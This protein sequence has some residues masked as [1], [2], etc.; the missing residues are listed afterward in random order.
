METDDFW[1]DQVGFSDAIGFTNASL[2][3]STCAKDG[4]ILKPS[5]PLAAI[6]RSFSIGGNAS[7]VAPPVPSGGHVW[8]THTT[9]AAMTWW[10][11]LAITVNEPWELLRTDLYPALPLSAELVV[12]D[13]RDPVGTAKL[14]AA[15][16]TV[17]WEIQT[18]AA[19][20]GYH[21]FEYLVIAPIIPYS[22]GWALLGKYRSNPTSTSLEN[23]IAAV[24]AGE[25]GKLTPIS[26]QRGWSFDM[27]EVRTQNTPH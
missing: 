17:L 8:A 2:V 22:G 5:L 27:A 13:H 20:E 9:A 10:S 15:N 21:G 14:I 23:L 19:A 16:A 24:V 12:Y 11:V 4:A 7:G 1:G 25:L 6:D 18:P 26:E 3:K